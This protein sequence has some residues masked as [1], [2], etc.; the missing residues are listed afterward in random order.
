MIKAIK[1]FYII[2]WSWSS[3]PI[4]QFDQCDKRNGSKLSILSYW[5]IQIDQ[6]DQVDQKNYLILDSSWS[7]WYTIVE[8]PSLHNCRATFTTQ[9]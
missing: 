8:Q 3:F 2:K 1:L 4:A 7:N 6:N 9:L 5:S